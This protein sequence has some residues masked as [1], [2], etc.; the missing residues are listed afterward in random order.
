[1]QV[2]INLPPETITAD[3]LWKA[4]QLRAKLREA[5]TPTPEE[6]PRHRKGRGKG[7]NQYLF[8][9]D[10][11][12][13][14]DELLEEIWDE[15]YPVKKAKQIRWGNAVTEEESDTLSLLQP[16]AEDLI[17]VS[18]EKRLTKKQAKAK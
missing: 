14:M 12:D 15:P 4:N 2:E 8:I 17:P 16:L 9:D 1:M 18:E 7:Q 13:E 5:L 3:V 11:R 6:A 10:I